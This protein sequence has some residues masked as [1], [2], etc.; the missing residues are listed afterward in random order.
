MISRGQ[1]IDDT[2][3]IIDLNSDYVTEEKST[4]LSLLLEL[5]LIAVSLSMLEI[6]VLDLIKSTLFSKHYNYLRSSIVHAAS[7]K[8]RWSLLFKLLQKIYHLLPLSAQ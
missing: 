3:L 7:S 5:F 8:N 6:K 2:E 1:D 4:K